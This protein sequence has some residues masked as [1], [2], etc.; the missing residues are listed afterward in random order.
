[1]VNA[2]EVKVGYQDYCCPKPGRKIDN[3]RAVVQR[4][5]TSSGTFDDE[6]ACRG[7]PGEASHT[8]GYVLESRCCMSRHRMLYQVSLRMDGRIVVAHQLLHTVR[9]PR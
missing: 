1:M 8:Y 7:R 9:V 6:V 3:E 4:H 5:K 2:A